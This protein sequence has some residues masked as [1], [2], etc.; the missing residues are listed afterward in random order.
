MSLAVVSSLC[1]CFLL[2]S[3]VGCAA[4]RQGIY[5]IVMAYYDELA[6][7]SFAPVYARRLQYYMDWMPKIKGEQRAAAVS[8]VRTA[9]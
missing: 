4:V 6:N 7:L 2:T 9:A 8:A 3:L 1:V 5:A